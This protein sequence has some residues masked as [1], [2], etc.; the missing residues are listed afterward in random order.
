MS[1]EEP[2]EDPGVTCPSCGHHFKIGIADA[3]RNIFA[4]IDPD[5]AYFQGYQ[6]SVTYW[7]PK[8]LV[9]GG[10]SGFSVG[11]LFAKAVL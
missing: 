10:L 11:V 4:G 8:L 2:E 3:M 1:N 6:E 9:A 5:D 7:F